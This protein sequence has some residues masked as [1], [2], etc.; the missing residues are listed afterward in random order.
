[1]QMF[2]MHIY[3]QRETIL[4]HR[5]AALLHT[6]FYYKPAVIKQT[7]QFPTAAIHTALSG[8]QPNLQRC[9]P[10]CHRYLKESDRSCSMKLSLH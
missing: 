9:T 2:K 4:T 7:E 1:M 6:L 3:F 10:R 5:Q 8:Y